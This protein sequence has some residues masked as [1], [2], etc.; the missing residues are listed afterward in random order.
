VSRATRCRARS[1]ATARRCTLAIHHPTA[2]ERRGRSGRLLESWPRSA[3]D[4][5]FQSACT[6]AELVAHLSDLIDL[7]KAE[8]F[9]VIVGVLERARREICGVA[10]SHTKRRRARPDPVFGWARGPRHEDR[11]PRT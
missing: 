8:G 6:T 3:S 11:R 5:D 10:Y 9:G 7:A 1:P 4:D 2:H